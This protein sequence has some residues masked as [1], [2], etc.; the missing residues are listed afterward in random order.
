MRSFILRSLFGAAPFF[1]LPLTAAWACPF[2]AGSGPMRL[3]AYIGPTA[4]LILL[5]LVLIVGVGWWIF[6]LLKKE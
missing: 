5:P 6:R 4:L 3:K 1:F 2:C